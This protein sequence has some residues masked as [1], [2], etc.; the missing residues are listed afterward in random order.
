[1]LFS[2]SVASS[3]FC[4]TTLLY[5]LFKIQ[6]SILHYSYLLKVSISKT[7]TF[8]TRS[9]CMA[10][11]VLQMMLPCICYKSKYLKL[12]SG[13]SKSTVF[14]HCFLL[15]KCECKHLSIQ[16]KAK[17]CLSQNAYLIYKALVQVTSSCLVYTHI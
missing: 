17:K 8:L 11:Y 6:I 12:S 10:F 14:L 4:Y 7:G 13:K 9:V 2:I 5:I 15:Q 1:M 3:F 16:V